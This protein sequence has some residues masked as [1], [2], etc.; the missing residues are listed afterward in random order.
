MVAIFANPNAPSSYWDLFLIQVF[1][2]IVIVRV[3]GWLLGLIKEPP[4]S[5]E[6]I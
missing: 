4:V 2:I 1:I 5:K 6:Y 3:M